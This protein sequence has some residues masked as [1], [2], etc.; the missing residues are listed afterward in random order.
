MYKGMEKSIWALGIAAWLLRV[1]TVSVFLAVML[2]A[3]FL[4]VQNR[5]QD[6]IVTGRGEEREILVTMLEQRIAKLQAITP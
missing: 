3:G 6:R 1:V 2:A 4:V 5:V